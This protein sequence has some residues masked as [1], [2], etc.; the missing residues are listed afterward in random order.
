MSY[1]QKLKELHESETKSVKLFKQTSPIP[2]EL[3]T[4]SKKENGFVYYV[5]NQSSSDRYMN[6]SKHKHWLKPK[7]NKLK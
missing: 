1:L 2:V 5:Y 3:A 6:S 7:F 4:L